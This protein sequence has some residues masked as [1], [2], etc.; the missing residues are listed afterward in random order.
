[1]FSH[2]PFFRPDSASCGPLRERGTI[3]R[4]VGAGYQNTLGKQTTAHL[5]GVLKPS[6]VFSADNRD[7]CEYNHH[8]AHRSEIR[9]VREVT[10]KSFSQARHIR[11]PGFQLLSLTTPLELVP[12]S[13]QRSFVDQPCTLPNISM[14]YTT[15]YW[16]LAVVTFLTLFY[17]NTLRARRLRFTAPSLPPSPKPRFKS[18][19]HS[20]LLQPQSDSAVWSPYTPI[21]TSPKS[22]F[23]ATLRTPYV[24]PSST[25][26][27]Q[28]FARP[29]T[30]RG[31][32][33]LTPLR[34]PTDEDDPSIYP[35]QYANHDL[36]GSFHEDG[37]QE[38]GQPALFLPPPPPYM[39]SKR[40]PGLSWVFTFRGR[41]RCVRIPLP[42]LTWSECRDLLKDFIS[43][44]G[45]AF[46]TKSALSTTLVD[47]LAV[48]WPAVL[49]WLIIVCWLF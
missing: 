12:M 24:H 4:G 27:L 41:R 6:V 46:S 5:L 37:E 1:V 38:G 28:A 25:P 15:I 19:L 48:F 40:K 36:D 3:R 7:Y 9:I 11:N 29:V 26:T 13:E 20:P 49:C 16:P 22:S 23:P 43:G 32:P 14:S 17:I 47:S 33:L 2:I 10:V 34:F 30:P 35:V 18:P 42:R 21:T 39:L 31:S 8:T 44:S 45:S